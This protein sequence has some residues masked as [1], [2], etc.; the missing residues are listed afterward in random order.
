MDNKSD[1]HKYKIK[2]N[3]NFYFDVIIL[4]LTKINKLLDIK[5]KTYL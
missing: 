1:L 2:K 3:T 4:K 5:N